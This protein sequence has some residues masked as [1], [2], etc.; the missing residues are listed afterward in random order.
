MGGGGA[1]ASGSS[2]AAPMLGDIARTTASGS[3]ART[4]K[5][6]SAGENIYGPFE[7]GFS[8]AQDAILERLGC[9]QGSLGHVDGGIDT[10]TAEQMIASQC[11]IALPRIEGSMYISLL[12]ECGGHTNQYHFHERLSCLYDGTSGGHS[13]KVGQVLDGKGLYGK[14]EHTSS[15]QLPLLDACGGHYGLTP[16]SPSQAVYHYHVQDKAPFTVGCYGPN[17]DGSLVT[18]Q[19]CR[20]FY[21]GCDGDLA[22]ITTPAGTRSYD[23]WCPCY[24]ASGSNTGINIVQLAAFGVATTVDPTVTSTTTPAMLAATTSTAMAGTT[25]PTTTP[26][27]AIGTSNLPS[28]TTSAAVIGTSNLRAT[29]RSSTTTPSAKSTTLATTQDKPPRRRVRSALRFSLRVLGGEFMKSMRASVGTPTMR[30]A[31]RKSIALA[32]RMRELD[33]DVIETA[34]RDTR[35]LAIDPHALQNSSSLDISAQFIVQVAEVGE[36]VSDENVVIARVAKLSTASSEENDKFRSALVPSMAT[37]A[38]AVVDE[39]QSSG[40]AMLSKSV[41]PNS[42]DVLGVDAPKVLEEV[43]APVVPETTQATF[44]QGPFAGSAAALRGVPFLALC[45][46]SQYVAIV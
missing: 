18:V 16:E 10:Y 37:T 38:A 43:K 19:Q 41:V 1:P 25:T 4:G 9:A 40:F 8:S 46:L 20:D 6:F 21:S 23:K 2:H 5:L 13:P 36:G 34:V 24:D 28:T 17:D 39:E 12:D 33:V 3:D 44:P 42:I 15:A 30:R 27:S 11:S 14:W 22:T 29:L 35:R 32:L 31:V 26:A 45:I 7:A